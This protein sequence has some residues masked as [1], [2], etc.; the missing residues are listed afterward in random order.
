MFLFRTPLLAF[1]LVFRSRRARRRPQIERTRSFTL[2]PVPVP[3]C[4]GYGNAA[5]SWTGLA[6]C[7][8]AHFHSGMEVRERYAHGET[9]R[10]ATLDRVIDNGSFSCVE[11]QTAASPIPQLDAATQS[12]R[13]PH[14]P[15]PAM[16]PI[17]QEV[18]DGNRRRVRH[19]HRH[20]R[21]GVG[22]GAAIGSNHP[23]S[24]A[25]LDRRPGPLRS[26]VR[27][28]LAVA[29][30]GPSRARSQA[31]LSHVPLRRKAQSGKGVA[32]ECGPSSP[33]EKSSGVHHRRG[34][35]HSSMEWLLQ[36]P[37]CSVT[38]LLVLLAQDRQQSRGGR[39]PLSGSLGPLGR[40]TRSAH[41][42]TRST[43][44]PA[45]MPADSAAGLLASTAMHQQAGLALRRAEEDRELRLHR[46]ERSRRCMAQMRSTLPM[47]LC[48]VRRRSR[49]RGRI[50]VDREAAHHEYRSAARLGGRLH[51]VLRLPGLALLQL[52][53]VGERA[54]SARSGCPSP[55][56]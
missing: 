22:V 41:V 50:R 52:L 33:A 16:S 25:R 55:S 19:A 12:Y 32:R 1:L 44:S 48:L 9:V 51:H 28:M 40:R 24:H 35:N 2:P 54:P 26:A 3:A 42:S 8:P 21:A 53:A 11:H 6:L 31:A 17:V 4:S 46:L 27:A 18:R 47:K 38:D 7:T 15:V 36:H 13:P 20:G 43:T 37:A 39:C 49:G 56:S 34:A 30:I 29:F 10:P 45:W 14:Y 23:P 5:R